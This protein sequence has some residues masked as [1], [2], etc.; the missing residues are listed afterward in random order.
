[1]A[2]IFVCRKISQSEVVQS[3]CFHHAL[4]SA[5]VSF[6]IVCLAPK[7]DI[8]KFYTQWLTAAETVTALSLIIWLAPPTSGNIMQKFKGL[9]FKGAFKGN[10]KEV[11]KVRFHP[12]VCC[13]CSQGAMH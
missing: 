6:S 5:T 2:C 1:M 11:Q 9:F 13:S 10:I 8:S 4:L 12:C 3:M 7:S